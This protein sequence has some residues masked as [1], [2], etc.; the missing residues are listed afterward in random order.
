MVLLNS[1]KR[2]GQ[3]LCAKFVYIARFALTDVKPFKQRILLMVF[4]EFLNLLSEVSKLSNEANILTRAYF[5]EIKQKGL[6]A[7]LDCTVTVI[8]ASHGR[9]KATKNK[10]KGHFFQKIYD[11]SLSRHLC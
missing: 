11:S 4:V 1:L 10:F 2:V 6:F 7:S 8:L 5:N 9:K 3:L